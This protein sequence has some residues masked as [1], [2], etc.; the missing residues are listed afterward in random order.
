MVGS[1][2][3]GNTKHLKIADISE[4]GMLFI[5]EQDILWEEH[6]CRIYGPKGGPP[7]K[8]TCKVKHKV[9]S[10]DDL[11][12]I[13]IHFPNMAGNVKENIL[14]CIELQKESE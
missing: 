8:L 4:E 13:G 9:K 1:S 7:F 5:S 14:N 6:L 11:Y 10:E 3:E 12:R 2:D